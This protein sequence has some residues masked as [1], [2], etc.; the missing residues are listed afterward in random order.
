MTT[1]LA[2]H[3]ASGQA[4]FSGIALITLAV[5]LA[6]RK[7]GRWWSL[8]R[9]VAGLTGLILIAGSATPAPWWF[10][11]LAGSTTIVWI[12]LERTTSERFRSMRR[13]FRGAVLAAWWLGAAL[14][15]PYHLIPT[16]PPARNPVVT[17]I[18]DSISAGV[19]GETS[20]WPKLLADQRGIKV[21]DL[22]VA[23]LDVAKALPQARLVVVFLE[24]PLPPTYN[25]FGM[26][27]RRLAARHK[28]WLV[29][30]R[31]LMGILASGG[32]TLDSI[33]LS[34]AG[35]SRMAR[36]IGNILGPTFAR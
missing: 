6:W 27:Q 35:H 36:T 21:I 18:G 4:Y 20:T 9:T 29:P 10:Y 32:A 5:G 12:G 22:S 31:V 30:K 1:A 15:I 33:H 14:E 2:Y 34:E 13:G 3:F 28:A 23:G 11:A 8:T 25:Q 26:I 19:G 16:L 24:L 17:V 7:A